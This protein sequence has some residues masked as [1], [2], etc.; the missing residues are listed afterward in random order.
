MKTILACAL[1]TGLAG[2]GLLSSDITT[3][4]IALPPQSYSFDTSMFKGLP[5]GSTPSVPCGDQG[6]PD[7][8]N[9][10]AG[11]APNCTTTPLV[12]QPDNSSVNNGASVCTAVIPQSISNSINLSGAGLS[13]FPAGNISID[14]IAYAVSDNSLNV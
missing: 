13:S 3:T 4:K 8:C 1:L 11:P 10:P 12:C 5:T 14:S 6:I 9:P 2:C 7:C